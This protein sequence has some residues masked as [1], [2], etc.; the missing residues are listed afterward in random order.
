MRKNLIFFALFLLFNDIIEARLHIGREIRRLFFP[1]RHRNRGNSSPAAAAPVKPTTLLTLPKSTSTALPAS[2]PPPTATI[3]GAQGLTSMPAEVFITVTD[4]NFNHF[5]GY[6]T[7]LSGVNYYR[8]PNF[9]IAGQRPC[10][11]CDNKII[12]VTR[13]PDERII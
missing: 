7:P 5:L 2:M 4:R 11:S 10:G 8:N 6:P 1:D 3:F 9:L 13:A 12:I